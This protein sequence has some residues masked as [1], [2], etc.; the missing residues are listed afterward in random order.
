MSDD[1]REELTARV[2]A[3]PE[4]AGILLSHAY[5]YIS[6][7]YRAHFNDDVREAYLWTQEGALGEFL[8]PSESDEAAVL[9]FDLAAQLNESPASGEQGAPAE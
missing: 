1:Y 3:N 5:S 9:N 8:Y 2:A 4:Q 7:A 6:E